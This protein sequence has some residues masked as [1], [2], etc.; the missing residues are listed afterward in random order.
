MPV[1]VRPARAAD[2]AE[3]AQMRHQLWP[4]AD[5]DHERE[6]AAFFKNR[7]PSADVL[8]AFDEA[9]NAVGFAELSIRSH[10]QACLTRNV[11]FLEGWFVREHARGQGIGA[12]L[13]RAA[14]D[15]GRSRGC[16]EFAS[17]TNIGNDASVAAHKSLGFEEVDRVVCFRKALTALAIAALIGGGSAACARQQAGSVPAPQT[18]AADGALVDFIAR[19]KAVDNHAHV[20]STAADDTEYDALPLEGIPPFALPARARPE[21]PEWFPALHALYGYQHRDLTVEHVGQ[22]HQAMQTVRKEQGDKFPE[23]VL[24]RAGIEVMLANR[25]AMGPG[26]APPRFRWVPFADA[27]M[28]PLSTRGEAASTP[29]RAVLY[30]LEAKLLRRYFD[31]L[32]VATPPPT[33]D[34]YLRTVVTPTLERQ[35]QN[36][37]VAVKFEA[38][39]LRPLA[40]DDVPQDAAA[41]VY[42][43]YIG[44]AEPPHGE[45]KALQDFLFRYIAR[46]A[47]RLGMAVHV[48]AFEGAGGFYDVAG[49]NPLLLEPVF[50]TPALR[51]TAFVIVHG[52]GAFASHTT[53]LLAKP[54]V[55]ADTSLMPLL[56]SR[57]ALAA[58]LRDWLSQYPE[59]VLFGTDAS[60]FGPEQGWEVAAWLAADS[61]R[62][63]LA[64]ALTSMMN[65]GEIDRRRAEEIATM[66]MRTSA[67]KLY[68][69]SSD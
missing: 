4:T 27:L 16:R 58:V 6:I 50:D 46:E 13:V 54:N 55:Y 15:W 40:F 64:S 24:D 60:G 45:Y 61:V 56:Y 17:D 31:D 67:A 26:L 25:V 43:R 32:K 22:L 34:G 44:G 42:A 11:A 51:S 29:D 3:W 53:G 28:L 39:Y 48:H 2:A 35:R 59:K 69:L 14:E 19:I 23:W 12:A 18:S 63:A 47:G 37:A 65:T 7:D 41:R 1:H 8:L 36:G 66:V 9:G 10:A 68:K 38:A 21:S 20:N 33:L 49:S 62:Q 30:P 5:E 52:G 57:D